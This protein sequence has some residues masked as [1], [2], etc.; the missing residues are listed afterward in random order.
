M[1]ETL[2]CYKV[3]I[4]KDS[5]E[6]EF[7]KTKPVVLAE[8]ESWIVLDTRHYEKI[9]KSK[10]WEFAYDVIERP[11]IYSR[12]NDK[13]LGNGVFYSLHTRKTKRT[14]TIKKEIKK[15][16]ADKYGYLANIDL[17]FIK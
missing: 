2:N 1:K 14:S 17:S 9:A 13:Y 5:G 8:N 12:E 16:I 3:C 6:P 4:P 10:D 11:K 7:T 15:F